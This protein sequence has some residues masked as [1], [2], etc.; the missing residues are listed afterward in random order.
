MTKV[1]TMRLKKG[2]IDFMKIAA[3]I[4]EYNPFHNG[5]AY[6]IKKT[7]EET[8]ADYIIALMSGNYVQR[9]TPAIME[10]HLRTRMA[11]ENGADLVIELPL[12]FSCA[13]APYFALGSTALLNQLGIIDVLSFG[14]ECGNIELLYEIADFLSDHD[15]DISKK[16]ADYVGLG[17][18]YPKARELALKNFC[19]HDNWMPVLKEPNNILGLEYIKSLI[20]LKSSIQPFCISRKGSSHHENI[21]HSSISSATSIRNQLEHCTN[22]SFV[23][24]QVPTSCQSL[25]KEHFKKDFPILSDDFSAILKAAFISNHTFT[26]FWEI[27]SDFQNTMKKHYRPNI[28]YT[29][30]ITSCKSRNLTWTRISRNLLHIMLGITEKHRYIIKK[31]NFLLYYQILGFRKESSFLIAQIKEK[32][33]LPMIRHLNPWKD[34]LSSDLLSLLDTERKANLL[35]QMILGEKFNCI[36]KDEQIIV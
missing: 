28:S 9:G 29:Q 13:S 10:K 30:F 18:P 26:N 33:S 25:L 24:P 1:H 11:L 31:H 6:H 8:G 16:T 27:S 3:I 35:Y 34:T 7:K 32:C 23:F 17:H 19:F 14:S 21:L 12:Y 5:H 15:E 36:W 2:Y 20:H 4:C 22:I